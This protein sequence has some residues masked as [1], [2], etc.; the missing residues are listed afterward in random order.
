MA[1]VELPNGECLAWHCTESPRVEFEDRLTGRTSRITGKA[2]VP[3][4]DYFQQ[5]VAKGTTQVINAYSPADDQLGAEIINDGSEVQIFG[6]PGKPFSAT[7]RG[8][9]RGFEHL[10]YSQLQF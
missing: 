3:I 1:I 2:I 4:P 5:S 7:I 6:Q 10:H 8:I 9:R